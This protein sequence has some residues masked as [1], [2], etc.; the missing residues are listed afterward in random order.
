MMSFTCPKCGR[1]SYNVNDIMH[2]FCG[3]CGFVDPTDRH[4]FSERAVMAGG[5]KTA[6]A[7]KVTPWLV[8]ENELLPGYSFVC[9]DLRP[10]RSK[11]VPPLD[12]SYARTT[13]I[14]DYSVL[15]MNVPHALAVKLAATW[16]EGKDQTS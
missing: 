7:E 14:A 2:S 1:V 5:R 13:F 12:E 10:D 6:E 3:V 11:P 4:H 9:W 15:P 16:N 8:V